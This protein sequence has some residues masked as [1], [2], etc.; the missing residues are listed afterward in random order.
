MAEYLELSQANT[1]FSDADA[2]FDTTEGKI[3]SNASSGNKMVTAS[4]IATKADL[5]DGKVPAAQL[6]SF[7]DDVLEYASTSAFPATGESGKIYVT[8]DTNKTYRWGGSDYVEI[9]ESLA[10]GETSS[11]A[12]AGDKGKANADAISDIQDL[13][14]SGASTS[15]KLAT[16]SDIPDTSG[17]QSK[18]LS[19]TIGSYTTVEG[20]LS[21]INDS[22]VDKVT[23]KGLSTNDYDATAKGIVDSIPLT[24][25][26][27]QG[28]LLEKFPRS[29]QAV[30]GAKNW[31]YPVMSG[32]GATA[33]ISESGKVIR[34][35]N[36][37]AA[38]YSMAK[39]EMPI[40][41]NTDFTLSFNADYTSGKGNVVISSVSDVDI[42]AF[43]NITS[44][45]DGEMTFNSGNNESII[46][47]VLCTSEVSEV[48]D[49]TFNNFLLSFTSDTNRSWVPYAMTNRQLT[50]QLM[51]AETAVTNIIE[52]ASVVD[53]PTVHDMGNHLFKMG[54]L[55]TIQLHLTHVTATAWSDIIFRV[56]NGFRP[57]ANIRFNGIGAYNWFVD[58]DG[59]C[60]IQQ[61]VTDATVIFTASWVT[62]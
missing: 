56:P 30:L 34:V 33:D 13:I 22:K 40:V 52:G 25:S 2:R 15:N 20:A 17:L 47:K 39:F 31:F 58:T 37:T 60:K 54:R 14:P 53:N 10:L 32:G 61:K 57:N 45:I 8:L 51:M 43:G 49:I 59:L 12:Y 28:S 35:H 7:V 16:A 18:N 19:T 6:P 38:T 44:N 55:V 24:V 46:V 5:V 27:L 21:G 4:D 26:Q 11:T 41:P 29:E 23:G 36:D 3:P 48:G 62:P 50:N 42:K 9:S 1:L